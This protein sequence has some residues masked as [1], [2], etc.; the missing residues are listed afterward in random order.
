MKEY[1]YYNVLVQYKDS[2]LKVR[3]C[4]QIEQDKHCL[5]SGDTK[6]GEL[7]KFLEHNW[8]MPCTV[9]DITGMANLVDFDKLIAANVA[10]AASAGV[11]W[12]VYP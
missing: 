10:N 5:L 11:E 8:W 4:V 3:F 9:L 7:K 2:G 1:D 6:N 12:E